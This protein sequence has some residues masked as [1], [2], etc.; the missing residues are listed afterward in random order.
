MQEDISNALVEAAQRGDIAAQQEVIRRSLPLISRMV[1]K[2]S[3]KSTAQRED[4]QHE[5]VLI[6]YRAIAKYRVLRPNGRFLGYLPLWLRAVLIR[7]RYSATQPGRRVEDFEISMEAPLGDGDT[8]IGDMLAASTKSAEELAA[9]AE[10]RKLIMQRAATMRWDD[11]RIFRHRYLQD[12]RLQEIADVLR[13]SREWVR[14]RLAKIEAHLQKEPSNEE[15]VRRLR[16]SRSKRRAPKSLER[17]A[18][19][20]VQVDEERS[21]DSASSSYAI[22]G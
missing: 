22:A 3:P 17:S 21:D 19:E 10:H 5:C 6:T 7:R 14:Q 13:C 11:Q 18:P 20:V 16:T 8:S 9:D 12:M 1:A 2:F 15:P 4:L